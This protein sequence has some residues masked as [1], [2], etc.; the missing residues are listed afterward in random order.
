[1]VA[2]TVIVPAHNEA[3]VIGRLLGK[4]IPP[5]SASELDVVVVANGCTDDTVD[6]AASYSPAV[7][8]LSIPTASK[9]AAL[10]AGNQAA[11]RFPRI[12]VD[13]DVELRLQDVRALLAALQ[14]PGILAATTELSHDF[15]AVGL[16]V[17]WYYDVWTRLPEV[18]SGLFGRGVVAL[19][20]AGYARVSALPPLLADDLAASLAFSPEERVVVPGAAV[21]VHPPRTL[22]DLLRIRVRACVGTTQVERTQGAPP[23]TART[24]PADL[25]RMIRTEPRLCPQM[26]I[27]LA[28]AVTV[29]IRASRAVRRG[30]YSTWLRDDS[31][32][33]VAAI[34]EAPADLS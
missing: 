31:T 6:V 2:A 14:Q 11:C 8:V 23:S 19:T 15:A 9:R 24:R 22:A 13:A 28:V 1:M 25:L 34:H 17:R 12:Y 21:I 18:R 33:R 20:A 16:P 27:F 10:H 26:L 5:G 32:R 3:P 30:D 29:R 7:R 4:L